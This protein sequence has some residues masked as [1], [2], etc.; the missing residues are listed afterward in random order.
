MT[1][2]TLSIPAVVNELF[3]AHFDMTNKLRRAHGNALDA[4]GLVAAN[5]LLAQGTQLNQA[6]SGG[7]RTDLAVS[8][9]GQS[10]LHRS[11]KTAPSERSR[12]RGIAA[13]Y[14]PAS[15]V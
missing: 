12:C 8:L 3:V 4:L 6:V 7:E 2:Q 1:V 14:W 9:N 15:G 11:V 5:R 13:G 10:L